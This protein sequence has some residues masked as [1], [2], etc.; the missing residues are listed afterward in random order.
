MNGGRTQLFGWYSRLSSDM[1]RRACVLV[2]LVFI[3]VTPEAGQ[4]TT[5]PAPLPSIA[6]LDL[7]RVLDLYAGGGFEEAVKRVAQAGDEIGRHL[8][9]HWDVTGRQW[10]DAGVE[11]RPQRVLAAA[12]LAL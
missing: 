4:K 7:P 2:L 12:A 11:H 10:I 1:A 8:R 6:P 5:P 3:S 9:R